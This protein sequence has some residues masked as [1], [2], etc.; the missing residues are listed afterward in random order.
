[1]HEI[2][3]TK[4]RSVLI[5]GIMDG[6][7]GTAASTM[8]S[9][10][11]P[12]LLSNQLLVNRLS[13]PDAFKESWETV[14]N[15]YR[16]QC[17][18]EDE[19]IAEYDP[20]EG[21]L[22]ANTGSEDLVAGTT[23]SV[24]VLDE[25]TGKLTLLNCGDSRSLVVTS[26]GKV[27]FATDDHTPQTE[28]QRLKVGLEAGLDYSLPQCSISKWWLSVG[29]YQYAVGRS[30][31]G[32]FATSKGIVSDPDVTTIQV[33][34]GDM[35]V[36]ASDGLWDVMDSSEVAIDLRKMR[37]QGMPARDAASSLCSMAI[38]KGTPDNVSVAVVFL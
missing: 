15:A 5:A 35:L 37:K 6:H 1:L 19:C 34:A 13:V 17:T 22:M 16:Q 27:K 36:S 28:Q 23:A 25:K 3:D 31:E 18:N 24:M 29:E 11:L 21:I 2:H 14:C 26:Q 9:E 4:D 38:R 33:E 10:Q 32:P 7:G 12:N 30:L 8:V 20:V